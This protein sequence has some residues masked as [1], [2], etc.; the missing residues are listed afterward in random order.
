MKKGTKHLRRNKLRENNITLK[1]LNFKDDTLFEIIL[2]I[3][4][5]VIITYE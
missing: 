3:K 1:I 5:S 2:A 4:Y